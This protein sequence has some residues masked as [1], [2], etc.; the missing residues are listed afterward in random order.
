V[1]EHL[2]SGE[3]DIAIAALAETFARSL[4]HAAGIR[5]R[6]YQ[7]R[8]ISFSLLSNGSG[9]ERPLEMS[10]MIRG[11]SSMSINPYGFPPDRKPITI[12]SKFVL[13]GYHL[14]ESRFFSLGPLPSPLDNAVHRL[15]ELQEIN[16][17]G[18]KPGKPFES[19]ITDFRK[20][21]R[22]VGLNTAAGGLKKSGNRHFGNGIGLEIIEPPLLAHGGGILQEG[23]VL[24]LFAGKIAA[25]KRAFG[26]RDV[27]VV[28]KNGSRKI[29]RIP[30]QVFFP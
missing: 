12:E 30:S 24:S 22:K 17:A 13:N 19:L 2:Q 10:P 11:S 21:E 3:G 16:I 23:M 8:G 14:H 20:N 9:N 6:D 28:T 27:V 15:M 26:P 5:I 25:D 7:K 4:G 1:K 18:I 29:T